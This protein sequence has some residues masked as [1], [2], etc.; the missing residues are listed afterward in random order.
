MHKIGICESGDANR[1]ALRDRKA[2]RK[3]LLGG[4]THRTHPIVGLRLLP[5]QGLVVRDASA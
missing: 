2:S 1:P 5:K 3:Y 4:T